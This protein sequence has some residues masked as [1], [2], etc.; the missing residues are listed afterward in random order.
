MERNRDRRRR[1]RVPLEVELCELDSRGHA[2][3]RAKDISELGVCYAESAFAPRVDGDEVLLRF[4]LPGDPE[5]IEIMAMI[6]DERCLGRSSETR[7]TFIWPRAQDA[8]R[9]REYVAAQAA[10][11]RPPGPHRPV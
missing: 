6:A 10:T 5:P 3:V 1:T 9:I 4:Q 7:V 8:K 11:P 2:L